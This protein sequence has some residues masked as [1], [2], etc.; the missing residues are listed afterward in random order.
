MADQPGPSPFGRAL[1][2]ARLAARLTQEELAERAGLS[3]RGISDLE[4]GTRQAPRLD[5]AERLA[6]ALE[7]PGTSREDFIATRPAW[8]PVYSASM[9][10]SNGHAPLKSEAVCQVEGLLP[11]GG[12]LG[13]RPLH[14]LVARPQESERVAQLLDGASKWE[15]ALLLLTGEPGVGKTRLAQEA[16]LQAQ[17]LGFQTIV[18][19]CY[20]EQTC[21]PY[22]PF[23]EALPMAWRLASARVKRTCE[24]HYAELGLLLRTELPEPGA[25]RDDDPVLRL[26]GAVAAFLA[27]LAEDAP[28]AVLLDDLHWADS[29]SLDLL[30]HLARQLRRKRVLLLGTYRDIEVHHQ[31][32]LEATL[33]TLTRERLDE[34]ITLRRFSLEGTAALLRDR[35]GGQAVPERLCCIVHERTDGNPFFAEE[36]LAALSTQGV[37]RADGSGW[38]GEGEIQVDVPRSI[39]AAIGRRVGRLSADGQELLRLASVLGHDFD[40]AVLLAATELDE[41]QALA[42]VGVALQAHL[43]EEHRQCRDERYAFSHALIA[44]TLREAV[45]RFRQRRLHRRAAAALQHVHR[46]QPGLAAEVAQHLLAA[47]DEE[48][49]VPFLLQAGDQAAAMYAHEEALAQYQIAVEFLRQAGRRG[50]AAQVHRKMAKHLDGEAA[51]AQLREAFAAGEEAGDAGAQA[52]VLADLAWNAECRDDLVA[53][54]GY[55]EDGVAAMA[56]RRGNG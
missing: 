46:A 32:P 2:R 16:M 33:D 52:A 10:S 56:T 38:L 47:G 1:R 49:A 36:L 53:A 22:A 41:A 6:D 15:G 25:I 7:L 40:L 12:F 51:E 13:A 5:T 19:R 4:R 21:Q 24:T 3:P 29:A 55:I 20:E 9:V 42:Q 37:V 14:A 54:R 18:G 26:H 43:L 11:S 35:L 28:L 27:S 48:Q 44:E 50:E 23:R 31:H 45:P 30:V 17:A 8:Q 39:R 34:T